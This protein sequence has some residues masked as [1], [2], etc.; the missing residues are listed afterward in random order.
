MVLVH[1][2]HPLITLTVTVFSNICMCSYLLGEMGCKSLK[3]SNVT[4]V[5]G[6]QQV[7]EPFTLCSNQRLQNRVH[8]LYTDGYQE[9][10]VTE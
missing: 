3:L 10:E 9:K 1:A 2:A 6:I 8:Q 7:L 4:T 5:E